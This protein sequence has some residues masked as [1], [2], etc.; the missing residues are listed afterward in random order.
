MN[1]LLNSGKQLEVLNHLIKIENV[2]IREHYY[3]PDCRLLRRKTNTFIAVVAFFYFVI[4]YSVYVQ[5]FHADVEHWILFY[6]FQCFMVTMCG[7]NIENQC[8][9]LEMCTKIGNN[10]LNTQVAELFE[11]YNQMYETFSMLSQAF[12]LTI[13]GITANNF[14]SGIIQTYVVYR[15]AQSTNMDVPNLVY[16]TIN[17]AWALQLLVVQATMGYRAGVV[18]GEVKSFSKSFEYCRDRRLAAQVNN[19]KMTNLRTKLR[20]SFQIEDFLIKDLHVDKTITAYGFY[21]LNESTI[22]SVR[23]CY[24]T[25]NK[26]INK[27]QNVKFPQVFCSIITYVVILIEFTQLEDEGV[28]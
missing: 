17:L 13:V 9:F 28:V 11:V 8:A 19:C 7:K 2:L 25:S 4:I 5:I 1:A 3:R 15:A 24:L 20:L 18:V 6:L 26:H 27:Q 14:M 16:N 10:Q 22:F 12:G 21:K 23:I